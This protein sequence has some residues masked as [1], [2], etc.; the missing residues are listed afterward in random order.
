MDYPQLYILSYQTGT[1]GCG[2]TTSG[3]SHKW[4]K[5]S[6]LGMYIYSQLYKTLPSLSWQFQVKQRSN[7]SFSHQATR[8]LQGFPFETA[9]PYY[10]FLLLNTTN[11]FVT[12]SSCSWNALFQTP[13][14]FTGTFLKSTAKPIKTTEMLKYPSSGLSGST[15]LMRPV[16]PHHGTSCSLPCTT[17][18]PACVFWGQNCN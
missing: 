1:L 7:S 3:M 9:R 18:S 6:S 8:L 5:S 10:L 2:Q 11:S 4:I 16:R 12:I 13:N 15:S 17:V 14:S